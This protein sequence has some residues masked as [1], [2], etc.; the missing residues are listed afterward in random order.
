MCSLVTNSCNCCCVCVTT[1]TTQSLLSFG[2]ILLLVLAMSSERF[3]FKVM[4]DRME[5]YR[6]GRWQFRTG[7]FWSW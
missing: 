4:V 5:S 3:L 6:C 7:S 1:V 2:A